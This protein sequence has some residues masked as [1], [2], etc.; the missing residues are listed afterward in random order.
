MN[1]VVKVGFGPTKE[2]KVKFTA[3]CSKRKMRR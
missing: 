3:P 2:M 1:E